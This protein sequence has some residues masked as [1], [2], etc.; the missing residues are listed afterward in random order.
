MMTRFAKDGT[1]KLVKDC[2]CPLTGVACVD[3]IYT[4]HAILHITERGVVVA[5]TFE[6][7]STTSGPGPTSPCPRGGEVI[8]CRSA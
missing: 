4:E 8:T 3:R 5:D 7:R 6:P 2:S 1:P